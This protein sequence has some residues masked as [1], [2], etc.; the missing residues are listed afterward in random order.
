MTEDKRADRKALERQR[1]RDK[2][3]ATQMAAADA[4]SRNYYYKR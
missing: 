4:Y 2:S 3:R 1:S